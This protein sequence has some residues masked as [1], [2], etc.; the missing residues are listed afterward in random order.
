M[1][2]ETKLSEGMIEQICKYVKLRMKMKEIAE[3]LGLHPGTIQSWIRNGKTAKS[4]MK[5]QLVQE[6]EKAKSE[7]MSEL[8][9]IVFNAAFIGSETITEKEITLPDGT[10]RKEITTKQSPPSAS[11]AMKVLA[12]MDPARWGQVQ[13][14]KI[15]WQTPVRELGLD[16]SQIEQAFFRYLENNQDDNSGIVIPEL[17]GRRI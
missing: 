15:D 14:I 1:P 4:G 2:R 11:Y 17:P 12:L 5:K 9:E 16:A 8:S 7:L 10:T 13:Q 3:I 6:I